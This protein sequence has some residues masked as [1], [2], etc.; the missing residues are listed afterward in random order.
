MGGDR[1]LSLT[2]TLRESWN[3]R[4]R[5]FWTVVIVYRVV[6]LLIPGQFQKGDYAFQGY[7]HMTS[8]ASEAGFAPAPM[9]LLARFIG[10]ITSPK[11]TFA[12]IVATPRWFAMMA[13]TAAIVAIF[14]ALPT[15]TEA[16]RQAFIDQQVQQRQS[17]G[18]QTDDQAYD[19]MEKMS[20]ITPYITACAV[21]IFTPIVVVI[22][23]GILFAVFN[24]ALGGEAS[25]KQMLAVVVHAGIISTLGSLISGIVNYFRGA[26][27]SVGNLG[28]LLPMLPEKSFLANL[29]GTVDIFIVWWLFVLAIG[30]GVLY[31]RRTQP[32]VM[33]LMSLYAVI[34]LVVA[35]VKSRLGGA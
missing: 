32:I 16:G 15:T 22:I 21:I 10:I 14:S 31:R 3:A 27:G 24:A 2:N 35:L 29:L 12:R 20:K 5:N 13:L 4:C 6:Q 30:L 23:A 1:C 25:F 26:I 28:A 9:G 33:S 7:P 8:T 17:F 19:Q 18:L 11:D 34:A